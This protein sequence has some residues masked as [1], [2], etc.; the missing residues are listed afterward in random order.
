[1]KVRL[2]PARS[3]TSQPIRANLTA[4]FAV[5]PDRCLAGYNGLYGDWVIATNQPVVDLTHWLYLTVKKDYSA[6]SWSLFRDGL[7]VLSNLGFA[8][9]SMARFSR[10][11]VEGSLMV[12]S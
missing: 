11:A 5:T 12:P 4:V 1:M 9:S 7:P 2:L 8:D 6:R 3:R 10:V